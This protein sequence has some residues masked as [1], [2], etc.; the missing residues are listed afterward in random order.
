VAGPEPDATEFPDEVPTLPQHS[1]FG[2]VWD[3]Q[4]GVPTEHPSSRSPRREEAP[5][6]EDLDV[7]LDGEPDVPEYL[8]AERRQQDRR[9]D[10]R[11]G[12]GG[13]GGGYR[14][15]LDRERF[16]IGSRSGYSR[17]GGR[18]NKPGH[19]VTPGRAS[20]H[21]MAPIEQTPGG[22][23]W[24]EVPPE[25]QELL[26]AELARRQATGAK[27]APET[28]TPA[29][30][31]VPPRDESPAAPAKPARTTRRRTTSAA[32][33]ATAAAAAEPE[34]AATAAE[35]AKP[36]RA[37]RRR[38]TAITATAATVAAE[39]EP[40]P[41]SEEAKP[42]RATRRRTTKAAASEEA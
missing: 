39:P 2:S 37:T 25:V 34:P 14:S 30:A 3:R 35:E 1:S 33:T 11:S 18:G 13:R 19:Q 6:D 23:P 28:R 24:S 16:G 32:D 9:R 22:D 7:E 8:L 21:A 31:A 40:A 12:R 36:K 17:S 42:K 20:A 41:A 27:Q 10:G 26:R 29:D 15:A 5:P 4:I 38:T